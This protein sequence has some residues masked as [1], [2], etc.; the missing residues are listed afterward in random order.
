MNLREIA[1]SIRIAMGALRMHKIRAALTTLGILIGVTTV[2]S[3]I[4]LIQGLNRSFTGQVAS[5][6]SNVL[7]VEKFPWFSHE[8]WYKYRNRK[9]I[10]R[11]QAEA[12][13]GMVIT[14]EHVAPVVYTR[15]PLK[16]QDAWAEAIL[17]RGTTPEYQEVAD[18]SVEYG[19]FFSQVD[20]QRRNQVC[21]L[22]IAVVEALFKD[23]DPLHKRVRIGPYKFLVVGVKEK[24][25]NLLGFNQDEDVII[26][27]R[28]FEKLFGTYRSLDIVVEAI[29]AETME[30]TSEEVRWAMR[31]IRKVP[32][33]EP[34][35]F[36]I[37][38]QDMLT[39]MYQKVTGTIYLVM[40]GIGTI[41]LVVG[42]IGIMNIMLVSVTERTREI[43][44]RKA[45]GAR[46]RNILWQFL[47][48]AVTLSSLGGVIGILIG[49][50]LGKLIAAV[51]PLP[52]A[53]SMWSVFLGLG[54]SSAVG[55][56]F[57]LYPAAKASRLDPIEALRYE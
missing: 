44:I 16:Y 38:Q 24:K 13:A 42:G 48:E 11:Q 31:L 12:L 19:R 22:G 23:V 32:P 55:I 15:R 26:P 45:L 47:V 10:T 27:I 21:V 7:Y 20:D 33:G 5:L 4:S 9:D 25:G 17:I 50:S 43:G 1:E 34:D 53:V 37:N 30:E 57:G 51:S 3:L 54:F 35:D 40:I 52:A 36:S 2:I 14:A 29:N 39:D 41:A 49:F 46:S 56:F 6:G 28:V 8:D 18:V